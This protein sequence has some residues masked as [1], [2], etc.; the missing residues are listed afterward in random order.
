MKDFLFPEYDNCKLCPRDC[1]VN[2]NKGE[3][4]F[5]HVDNRLAIGSICRH[6]GEEPPISGQYGIANVFFM[7]CTL[8]C[9]FCQ[10]RQISLNKVD[11]KPYI[12]EVQEVVEKLMLLLDQGCKAVGFV[13]P[14]HYIPHVKRIIS[15]LR[16]NGYYPS[17]VYNTSGYENVEQLKEL[18]GYIDVWLPD[19]KY[20]DNV[21]ARRLSKASN[22]PEVAVTAIK[23]MYRQKGSTLIVDELAQAVSGLIIRHLVLP[24]YIENSMK[25][26]ET[27]ADEISTNVHISLMS[28]YNPQFYSHTDLALQR[29]LYLQEYEVV[30]QHFYELG[31]HKGWI[32]EMES[33]QTYNPDFEQKHPFEKT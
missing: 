10:N 8:Q 23:E 15:E 13:S 24:G 30:V 2:R 4:G 12:F 27:I 19:F 7:H 33:H 29:P 26:L 5:C 32:Q 22:Y 16:S 28:Q 3:Y 17:F 18:E 9:Q 21:L 25:V 1:G 6:T 14:T 31:F 20:S 11:L